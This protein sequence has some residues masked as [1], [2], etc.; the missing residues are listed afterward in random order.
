MFRI[1]V[2]GDDNEVRFTNALRAISRAIT[3]SMGNARDVTLLY[4]DAPV[5]IAKNGLLFAL[6]DREREISPADAVRAAEILAG[7]V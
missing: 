4:E 6:T 7:L 2:T 1:V 3:E 5:C